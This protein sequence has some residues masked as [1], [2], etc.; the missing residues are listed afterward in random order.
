MPEIKTAFMLMPFLDPYNSYYSKIYKPTL[1]KNGINISRV[2]NLFSPRPIILDIQ[3]SIVEADIILCEMSGR[4]PNVFYELGLAH[5]IGKPVLLL[6]QKEEDIPFDLRHIRIIIYDTKDVQWQKK[7][8]QNLVA[9]IKAVSESPEFWPPP[10]IKA[11]PADNF[12]TDLTADEV[13][14]TTNIIGLTCEPD[15]VSPNQTVS[16]TFTIV[17]SSGSDVKAWLGASILNQAGDE[18]F[19]VS[20]DEDVILKAGKHK[21]TRY[22]TIPSNITPG[23]FRVIGAVWSGNKSDPAKSLRVSTMDRGFILNIS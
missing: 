4:N 23:D 16:L 3:K 15:N 20:Q 17:N 1:E 18:F 11:P 5:A 22:L 10:L 9:G 14:S 2:D 8:K 13:I 6:S 12:H 7:L 21:Y 19:N